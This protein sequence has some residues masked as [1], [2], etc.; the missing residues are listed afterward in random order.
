MIQ[1]IHTNVPGR[2]RYKVTALYRSPTLKRYLEDYLSADPD[3]VSVTANPLTGTVLIRFKPDCP[4]TEIAARLGEAMRLW[5]QGEPEKQEGMREESGQWQAAGTGEDTD[6]GTGGIVGEEGVS[7]LTP[8][9]KGLSTAIEGEDWYQLPL[10]AVLQRWGTDAERG[11]SVTMAGQRLVEYGPNQLETAAG[12]SDLSMLL[13][14]FTTW[15]VA[16]LGGAAL[17][18]GLTGGLVDAIVIMGVV[19]VNAVIGYVT[20]SQSEKI[21]RSLRQ[22]DRPLVQVRR[23]GEVLT[24]P[25]EEVVPGDLLL[26]RSGNYVAADARL[27]QANNLSIDESALTGESIAVS[28]RVVDLGAAIVPLAERV[29]MVFKG[30]FIVGGEGLAVV[31]A[32]GLATEMGKIQTLVGE[33]AVMETP[34]QRQLGEVSRQLVLLCGGVCGAIFAMGLARGYGLLEILKTSISLAVAAV[35]E[36]LPTVA[37]TTLALGIQNMRQRN[38][39]IRGLNAVETL[40]SV[41]VVCLDKTGTL[42]LNQMAVVAMHLA[43]ATLEFA[44]TGEQVSVEFTGGSAT[45]D[46][47]ARQRLLAIGVLCSESEIHRAADGTYTVKGTATENALVN[48]AIAQSVDV[49]DLRQRYPRRQ[50]NPRTDSRNLM[51]T[52]HDTP[53]GKPWVAVKGSPPEV[54]ERCRAFLDQGV[55]KPLTLKDQQALEMANQGL[56]DRA[57]RVLAM[58]YRDLDPDQPDGDPEQD[59]IWVGLVGLADPIRERV[60]TLIEQFHQAGIATVMVTGDQSP[61]AYAIGRQLH[62]NRDRQLKILDAYDLSTLEPEALTALAD[63]VDIFAR[64]SPADK[65]QIVRALQ[66]TNKIVAMTG[67]GINDTPALKA[68]N[69]GLAMGSGRAGVVH[70]VADVVIQDDNL[71]TIIDAV[72][73]G[74][75]IYNNIRKSVHFLLATNL[76]EIIVMAIA[77]LFGWGEPLNALQLLWLNLVTDV[78]PGLG[79][80]LEPPEPDILNQPPRDPNTPIIRNQD[81]QRIGLEASV[82][83]F[84][85]LVAYG[86]ALGKYGLG[87]KASTVAFM[88][89][90]IGQVLHTF[91]CRSETHRWFDAEKLPPNPYV[92]AAIVGAL[93]LQLLPLVVPG[94]GKILKITPLDPWDYGVIASAALLPLLINEATKRNPSLKA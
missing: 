29:N 85:T 61:T 67:D 60:P 64:I 33:T 8:P 31:T 37:T 14:Q 87:P 24:I 57:L 12:R 74:R 35:P 27:I 42:T 51:S 28:K 49:L 66:S 25:T 76:S 32:T 34:L 62:L 63:K 21:I 71:S 7:G 17:L 9:V 2:A 10:A 83:S 53:D 68:A 20:E 5:E 81:F 77:T 41:Q 19:G 72:S 69:V 82:L 89:L 52:I 23:D 43:T 84:F 47:I 15:P 79:L 75:T 45:I 55:V 86:Y 26:L 39:L 4:V 3:I 94:L 93:V 54:L 46:A 73:Q 78:F 92:E 11:L 56:A 59:L 22:G 50:L 36:G 1:A 80:A 65:L 58:A 6:E 90:T 38:I 13:E 70:E 88:S 44:P 48:L 18:S 40:G 91:S 30:T 16:L